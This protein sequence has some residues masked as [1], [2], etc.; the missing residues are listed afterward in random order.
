[1]SETVCLDFLPERHRM[2]LSHHSDMPLIISGDCELRL[3][4]CDKIAFC[5]LSDPLSASFIYSFYK[6]ATT[7]LCVP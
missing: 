5:A 4:A 1:M 7:R 6:Y 2:T 3:W